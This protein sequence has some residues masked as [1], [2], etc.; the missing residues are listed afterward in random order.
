MLAKIREKTQGIIASLILAFVAIPFILWGVSSYF[1]AGGSLAVAKV[2]G[3]EISQQAYRRALEDIR[4]AD[5]R[6]AE[7]PAF[8]EL[9]VE[10][11]VSQTL[12]ID[13][14]HEQGY[15]VSD[16]RLGRL[17]RDIP[18]FQ[19]DGRFDPALYEAILRREGIFAAEFESRLR[20]ESLAGQVQR[21]LSETAFVTEDDVARV[22][23]LLR[24]ERRLSYAVIVPESFGKTVQ[25]SDSE[26]ADYYDANQEAFRTTEEVRAEYVLLSAAEVGKQYQPTEEDLRQQYEADAARYVTPARRRAS[27]ILVKLPE[28]AEDAT[29]Q[30][31]RERAEAI[32]KELA[33]GV[34]FA[35]VAKKRSEDP[36]TAARGGDLG[37]IAPGLLP[38]DLEAAVSALKPGETSPPVRTRFG[39]H[40]VKLVS[41]TPEKRKAFAEVRKDLAE[42]VRAR[43]G[44]ERFLELSERFRNLVYEHPDGLQPAAQALGLEVRT[45]GWFS[46]AGGTGMAA[47][48]RFAEAAFE[49]EV[50]ARSRNSDAIDLS[51]EQL[52]AVRVIDHRPATLKPLADVRAAIERTLREQKAREQAR[53]MAAEWVSKLDKGAALAD[54]ARPLGSTVESGRVVTRDKTGGVNP[55]LV[56]AAFAAPRPAD[57]PVHGLVDLGSQGYAV[58][59]LE[60]ARDGDPANAD[61]E[62]KEKVRRQLLSRRGADYYAHYRAGLRAQ[63]DVKIYSDQL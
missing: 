52:V 61:A 27:H 62:A 37:D 54:L 13:E 51:P 10:S 49:H 24:Q 17:V 20:N 34:D 11:L 45:T 1:E 7:N 50:L 26:I 57:G 41:M 9:V 32:A 39:F 35:A 33:S 29:V 16:S 19:R 4:G 15:R 53:A 28:G 38:P 58:F 6:R 12:L 30:A 63:A 36:A 42:Q 43:K 22:L 25:P 14:A 60:Q 3:T 31:A 59:A 44:E 47:N 56:N 21:G 5:P 46:R 48:P 18:Y 55:R 23:R 2:N 8:R 40:I